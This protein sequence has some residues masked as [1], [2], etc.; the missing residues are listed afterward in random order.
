MNHFWFHRAPVS[1]YNKQILKRANTN[2]WDI[3]RAHYQAKKVLREKEDSDI[4]KNESLFKRQKVSIIKFNLHFMEGIDWIFLALAI[5]GI[6]IG[7]LSSPLLS[8]LNAII[9]SNVGNT[10]ENRENLSAEEIMKL[11][12]KEQMNSNIKK[13]LI[14]GSIELVGNIMGYGFFGLLCATK[15]QTQI[16]YIELGLGSRLGNILMDFFIGVA[17]FIFSF[18]GSWKLALVLLCFSPLSFIT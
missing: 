12:V 6:L 16:E 15:I 17:S 18:F 14:F 4:I 9:F 2:R 10:S 13:Q 8:Y 7:A 1:N 11:N 3:Q 5:I